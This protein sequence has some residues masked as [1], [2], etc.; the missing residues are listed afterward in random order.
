LIGRR[1]QTNGFVKH[2]FGCRVD[3]AVQNEKYSEA[4][5]GNFDYCV[6]P[7]SW[8]QL[9][10]EENVFSTEGLDGWIEVLG[11]KRI[12]TIAGPLIRLDEASVPDWMVIWEHDFD[13]LREMAYEFVQKVVTRYRRAVAAWNVVGGIETN[14]AFSLSFEQIIELTRLLVSQVKTLIPNARTMITIVCVGN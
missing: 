13:M 10:P 12:P 11:R 1:R 6:L 5:S 4:L 8:K 2:I 14:S 3:P 9:Q 7:M